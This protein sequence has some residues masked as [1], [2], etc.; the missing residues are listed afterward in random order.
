HPA[1]LPQLFNKLVIDLEAMPVALD[2]LVA[3]VGLTR[4]ATWL[5]T[6]DLTTQAHGAAKIGSGVTQL[7]LAFSIDPL[8]NQTHHRVQG[9][10][11]KLG[12]DGIFPADHIAGE[13]DD[14]YLHADTDRQ[15]RSAVLTRIASGIALDS[16]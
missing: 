2:H 6:T 1:G 5:E 3:T 12:R 14:R 16:H 9:V 7:D 10:V 4:F 8:G 11:G 15:I 13:L